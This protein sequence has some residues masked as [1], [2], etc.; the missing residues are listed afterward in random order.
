M[1]VAGVDVRQHP[2]VGLTSYLH[3][4][5]ALAENAKPFL[6]AGFLVAVVA[7]PW[8]L[9]GYLFGTDWPGPRHFAFPAAIESSFALRIGL[10]IVA[11]FLQGEVTTKSLILGSLFVAGITSYRALPVG[12]FA[13]RAVASIV[14][15][16]N[17]FVYGR[18]HY[19]QVFLL[20]GYAIL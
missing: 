7:A 20:A 4:I 17:P 13:P 15:V 18:L 8:V 9:P 5:A 12:G 14:Y 1:P 6:W 11:I 3:S 19:G 10:H 16:C 2:A